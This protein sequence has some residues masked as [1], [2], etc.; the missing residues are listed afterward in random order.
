MVLQHG[1]C[2]HCLVSAEETKQGLVLGS[3]RPGNK[4]IFLKIKKDMIR[5]P[6]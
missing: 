4:D 1:A 5:I 6:V 3:P 2:Q